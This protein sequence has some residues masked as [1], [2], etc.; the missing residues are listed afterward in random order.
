VLWARQHQ[1]ETPNVRQ[2]KTYAEIYRDRFQEEQVMKVS[3]R[4]RW[5]TLAAATMVGATFK[6]AITWSGT[7]EWEDEKKRTAK[8]IQR[9]ASSRPSLLF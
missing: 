1:A 4:D 9:V 6:K 3:A 2:V 7:R 5:R 8:D